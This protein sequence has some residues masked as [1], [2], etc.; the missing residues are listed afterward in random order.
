MTQSE[1][2]WDRWRRW[3]RQLK[4]QIQTLLLASKHPRTPW[5]ARVLAILVVAYAFSPIDLIPDP[6]PIL[7]YLDDLIL[8]PI[9]IWLTLRLIPEEVWTECVE[10]ARASA[11]EMR[12]RSWATAGVIVLVWVAALVL[13]ARALWPDVFRHR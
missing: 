9:G 8:L 10:R 5:F 12:P 1:R 3:A 6:I 2:W 4:T 11:G 13:T 7:G